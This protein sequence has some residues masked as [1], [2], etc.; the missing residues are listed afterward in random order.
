MYPL[1]KK[2]GVVQQLK[3]PPAMPGP[4]VRMLVGWRLLLLHLRFS[5]RL[6]FL[7]RHCN[8]SPWLQPGPDPVIVTAWGVNQRIEEP[9]RHPFHSFLRD[10]QTK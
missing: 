8:M 10:L 5:S 3:L 4:H 2:Y 1:S 7:G 6:T 9:L